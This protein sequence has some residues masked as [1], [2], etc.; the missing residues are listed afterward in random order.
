MTDSERMKYA[1]LYISKLAKGINPLDDS[2]IVCNDVINNQHISRCL[3]YVANVLDKVC[4]GDYFLKRSLR[5]T[6]P[7]D[8]QY[9]L[10][11][12]KFCEVGL[13]INETCARINSAKNEGAVR[14]SNVAV[15]RW[16]A[17]QGLIEYA[18]TED[19]QRRAYPTVKG[20][21]F[22]LFAEPRE[23]YH[24]KY[25]AILLNVDAQRAVIKNAPI[26]LQKHLDSM[27]RHHAMKSRP[28]DYEQDEKVR[29][30]FEQGMTVQEIAAV[31]SRTNGAIR[32]RLVK[33]GAMH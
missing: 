20:E 26:I 27:K 31:M 1:Y 29:H 23:G 33:L 32:S 2:A 30:M 21:K 10:K 7:L 3:E 17:E 11:N 12:F 22:G 14:V 18:E 25:T 19:G 8:V 5:E 4:K 6:A 16:F 24:G 28:W 9:L 13:L 15:K